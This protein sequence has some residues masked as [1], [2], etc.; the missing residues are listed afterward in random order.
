MD[1]KGIADALEELAA[2]VEEH[3]KAGEHDE[4]IRYLSVDCRAQGSMQP[5]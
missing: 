4:V 5:R 1:G 3:I 2:E